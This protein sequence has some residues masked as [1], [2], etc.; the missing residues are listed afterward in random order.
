[1]RELER[2]GCDGY[3]DVHGDEELE[4]NFISGAEG[5][6]RWDESMAELQAAFLEHFKRASPDFQVGVGYEI[7]EPGAAN[8]SV[9]SNA[10]AEK[11]GCLGVTLEQPFKDSTFHT[12]E[13][14]AGWSAPRALRLGASLVDALL[15]SLPQIERNKAHQAAKAGLAKAQL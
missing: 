4:A 10:I 5:V 9:C 13:P 2:A 11:F 8:L 3:V 15:D 6:P 7:D 12:P 1:M 14:V